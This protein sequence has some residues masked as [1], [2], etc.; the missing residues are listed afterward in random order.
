LG[1]IMFS[2]SCTIQYKGSK[3]FFTKWAWWVSKDAEIN[4][5]F[6]NINLYWSQNAPKKG[7]QEKLFSHVHTG[8]PYVYEK[9]VFSSILLLLQF[10]IFELYVK[11]FVFWYP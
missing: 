9:F 5:D 4:V 11:F 10:D 7:I 3:D 8:A 1:K 2:R 6:K